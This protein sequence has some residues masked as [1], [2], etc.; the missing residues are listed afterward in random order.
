MI[1]VHVWEQPS[2][3]TDLQESVLGFATCSFGSEIPA[4]TSVLVN[5]APSESEL[6][7]LQAVVVPFA[8]IPAATRKLLLDRPEIRLFNLHHNR[9]DTA[10]MALALYFAVAKT[11]VPL[12]KGLREGRWSAG[13]FMRGGSDGSIRASGKRAVVLGMGAIGQHIA[14]VCKAMGMQVIGVRR[15]GPFDQNVRSTQD[16]K[17]LLPSADALFIALP[18]TPETTGLVD[19]ESIRLLP[20]NAIIVNIGRGA[21]IH[22]QALYEALRDHRIHGAGLDVWWQY[23]DGS[24]N[25]CFPSQFPFHELPNVVM[26]PHIGG[27]SDASEGDRWRALADLISG[28]ASGTAN[29][30]SVAQGY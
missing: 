25:P 6:T 24:D 5:G 17:E 15:T 28:I 19:E 27:S 26:T 10:E 30:V 12:D 29:Q 11:V 16:L 22:E 13:S 3:A 7:G 18:L 21:I 4:G 14:K 9:F 23:P 8:G 1:H 20:K 2:W